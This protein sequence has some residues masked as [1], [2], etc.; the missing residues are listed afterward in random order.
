MTDI[1]AL[2]DE[3]PRVQY[4]ADGQQTRFSFSFPALDAQDITSFINGGP[5]NLSYGVTLGPEGGH[6]DFAT[7]PSAHARVTILRQTPALRGAAFSDHGELAAAALNSGFD[8]LT[9]LAQESREATSR[10]ALLP[11]G[12]AAGQR[13][14]LP[15]P[16]SRRALLWRADGLGLE[17][18]N[19]DPDETRA[20]AEAARDAAEAQMRAAQAQAQAA[21]TAAD[22][23][24]NSANAATIERTAAQTAR[25]GAEAAR[26]AAIAAAGGGAVRVTANDSTAGVLNA[27]LTVSGGLQKTVLDGGA[28]ESLQIHFPDNAVTNAK[29]ANLAVTGAKIA[30]GTISFLNLSGQLRD[31][32]LPAGMI[33]YFPGVVVPTGWLECN[34]ALLSRAAYPN[35]WAFA[36]AAGRVTDEGNWL[37]GTG[38]FS[39][40]NGSTTFRIP[41]LRGEFLRGFDNGR[42]VDPG[43]SIG[44][45]QLDAMQGHHHGVIALANYAAATSPNGN[46][47]DLQPRLGGPNGT[48][49][50][51]GH[52]VHPI[53]DQVNGQP[54]T[55]LETRP[56]NIAMLACIKF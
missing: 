52:V 36:N 27:K 34:G 32:L 4:I 6:V 47:D 24:A 21:Q 14:D 16:Q 43:R 25:T 41:D 39:H 9:M 51:G 37:G 19:F 22:Q 42:G 50:I 44:A 45:R 49:I 8:R 38:I 54:R 15:T 55:G 13:A 46:Y 31:L 29:I 33:V 5:T 18:S 11:I 40:G 28:N 20:G 35:L 23:A 30:E 2:N 56:R 48:N 12:A 1:F 17:N 7:P 26:D 10:A 3:I 53:T